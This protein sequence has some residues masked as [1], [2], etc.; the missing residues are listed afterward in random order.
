[1]KYVISDGNH[2]EETGD[3]ETLIG[4]AESW[5]EYLDLPDADYS[6]IPTGDID[7]LNAAI[8]ATEDAMA[9]ADGYT[10]TWGHGSYHVPARCEAGYQLTVSISD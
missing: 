4:Y 7:A 1:M 3:W 6:A 2:T 5:Y 8:T 9:E 10:D